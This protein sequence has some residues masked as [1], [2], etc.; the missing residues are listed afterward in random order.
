[1]ETLNLTRDEMKTLLSVLIDQKELLEARID[2]LE[3][4]HGRVTSVINELN[5]ILTNADTK[6]PA[7]LVDLDWHVGDDRDRLNRINRALQEEMEINKLSDDLFQVVNGNGSIY[8]VSIVGEKGSCTC[9]DFRKRGKFKA[10]PCKHL[11]AVELWWNEKKFPVKPEKP[12]NQS[13]EG[14][15]ELVQEQDDERAK[16]IHC[17]VLVTGEEAEE[18]VGMCQQCWIQK[19][20]VGNGVLINDGG[21]PDKS[22]VCASCGDE[23]F[24]CPACGKPICIHC[25]AYKSCTMV[26]IND[27]GY[28]DELGTFAVFRAPSKPS[29]ASEDKEFNFRDDHPRCV[30]KHQKRRKA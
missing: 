17:G 19:Q 24:T 13:D 29:K 14:R 22:V 15:S 27:G 2:K 8:T 25:G 26:T 16:C 9:A 11:Y 6:A 12:V 20:G 10:M 1:M 28:V 5:E 18:F 23:M 21:E 7:E 4:K 3:F 30:I